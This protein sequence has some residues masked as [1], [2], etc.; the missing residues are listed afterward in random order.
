MPL[1]PQPARSPK[2]NPRPHLT[3]SSP[4]EAKP[5]LSLKGLEVGKT[6]VTLHVTGTITGF[7]SDEYGQSLDVRVESFSMDQEEGPMSMDDAL[8]RTRR[9]KED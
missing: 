5:A 4:K 1:V 9:R 8:R 3:V 6:P 7:R 2:P